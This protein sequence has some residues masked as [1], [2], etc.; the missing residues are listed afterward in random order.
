[1][2]IFGRG[3]KLW[4]WRTLGMRQLVLLGREGQSEQNPRFR[5]LEAMGTLNLIFRLP[6]WILGV[7]G[8]GRSAREALESG[9]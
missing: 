2:G 8:G 6:S 9:I 1:M 7:R 4:A 3:G 5:E